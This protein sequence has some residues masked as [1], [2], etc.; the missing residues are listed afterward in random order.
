MTFFVKEQIVK[1]Q[2]FRQVCVKYSGTDLSGNTKNSTEELG[3]TLEWGVQVWK[4]PAMALRGFISNGIDGSIMAGIYKSVKVETVDMQERSKWAKNGHTTVYLAYN[5]DVQKMHSMLGTMF[6]HF[7]NPELLNNRC[8]PKRD[9]NS[10]KVL[11]Y[12]KGVLVCHSPGKS[13]FDYNL[14]DELTLDESRNAHEW[15]V[16]YSV[17]KALQNEF[18]NNL[19]TIIKGIVNTPDVWESKLDSAYLA[20]N[21]AAPEVKEKR[22]QVF[23]EAWTQVAGPKGVVTSGSVA[24]NSSSLKRGLHLSMCRKDGRKPLNPT[25]FRPKARCFPATNWTAKCCP[26]Q[27]RICLTAPGVWT[28]LEASNLT[29]NKPMPNTKGF[30]SVMDGSSQTFGYYIPGGSDVYLHTSLAWRN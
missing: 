15:D 11:I 1:G 26:M 23:K 9:P 7:G 29:N 21:Y 5:N 6:L 18:T 12:K 30:M 27:L 4:L 3:F 14:G 8:L 13:V 22:K 19:T 25:T 20:D 16:K 2:V 17:A 10:D 28:L 24:L